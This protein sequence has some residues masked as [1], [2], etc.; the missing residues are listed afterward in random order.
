M[1]QEATT[2]TE[3]DIIKE[4]SQKELDDEIKKKKEKQEGCVSCF[5]IMKIIFF[6]K[7]KF[8][9]D[10]GVIISM[11]TIT[12]IAVIVVTIKVVLLYQE[13]KFL[14]GCLGTFYKV[15]FQV[16]DSVSTFIPLEQKKA[17]KIKYTGHG[18][19][20]C[21]GWDKSLEGK[22]ID[23]VI[24]ES[25]PVHSADPETNRMHISDPSRSLELSA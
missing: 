21:D 11:V 15:D 9:D 19:I 25:F 3:P 12:L 18:F 17:S 6:S 23:I 2:T 10:I 5:E 20:P 1:D 24:T 8:L 7:Q 16:E 4:K 13:V 14:K 22:L